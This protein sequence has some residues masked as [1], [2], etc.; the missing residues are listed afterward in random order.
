MF[1]LFQ[2]DKSFWPGLRLR[3][4]AVLASGLAVFAALALSTIDKFSIWFDEAFGSYLIRFDYLSLTRYT[5]SDVHP[6]LY[7]WL[8][9]TWSLVFGNTEFGIRSMSLFFGII[10]VALAFLLAYRLFGRRAAYVS[11][12][13]LSLSPIF[14]RYSQEARMYTLL[15]TIILAATYVL[16]Y[17]QEHTK[18]R[19]PW[20]AYGVLV[21]AGM[22]TQYFAALAWL[23]HWVWRYVAVRSAGESWRETRKKLLSKEWVRAHII[24]TLLFL[25]W[26]PWMVWQ[27]ALVQGHGFW[28][29]PVTSA[30]IP[31]FLT[32]FLLFV[33]FKDTSGWFALGFYAACVMMVYLVVR[34]LRT[35]KGEERTNYQLLVCMTIVP[36]VLLVLGSMPPLRSAF[37]DRYLIITVV[38][39]SLVV[40]VTLVLACKLVSRRVLIWFGVLIGL[41]MVVG[42]ANQMTIGNYNKSTLQSNNVR[43][44]LE[45]VRAKAQ[46][47]TPIVANTPWIYYEAS[48]YSRSDSQVYFVDETTEYRY[49]SL[50]ML[51]ENDEFKIKDVDAFMK[52]HPSFWVIANL[53]DGAPNKLRSSWKPSD[54]IVINDDVSHEPLF[55][56]VKFTVE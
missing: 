25:P 39:L 1:G 51:V 55:E 52:E 12:V 50:Q 5:A 30:T 43:Q 41:M 28:I 22:L 44:L 29:Q 46:P 48:I 9:K 42:I 23:T 24:A 36:V 34:L 13:F 33:D 37:V 40:G 6:P 8:L 31:N 32:D 15:I 4:W 27:F 49:G 20:A 18:K 14:I 35:L 45:A 47:G 53:R 56:A 7:Y 16:V 21:A 10:S 19:W 3:D 2:K 54:T 38:F 26:L 11:L 17:A